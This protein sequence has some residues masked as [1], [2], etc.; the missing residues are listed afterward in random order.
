MGYL[1]TQKKKK[2]RRERER[3]RGDWEL[4]DLKLIINFIF[5][6]GTFLSRKILGAEFLTWWKFRGCFKFWHFYVVDKNVLYVYF[7]YLHW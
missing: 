4:A 7:W 1:Y 6:Q 5:N 3:E 2:R